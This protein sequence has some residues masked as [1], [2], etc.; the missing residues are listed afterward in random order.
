MTSHDN[1][2]SKNVVGAPSA[3]FD[4]SQLPEQ[5]RQLVKHETMVYAV[6]CGRSSESEPFYRQLAQESH[7]K[8]LQLS[9]AGTLP[10]LLLAILLK[11]AGDN[12]SFARHVKQ[13]RSSSQLSTQADAALK[14]IEEVV[15]IR[16][17]VR[18]VVR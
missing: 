17:I 8:H 15:V 14:Q 2:T 4:L 11:Q 13:L 16:R 9:E 12:Q 3:D 7:G 18:R 1:L 5:L 10:K 6:Q